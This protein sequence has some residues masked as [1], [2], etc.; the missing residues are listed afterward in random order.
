MTNFLSQIL[1][2]AQAWAYTNHSF[3]YGIHPQKVSGFCVN[4]R[5][6]LDRP[7]S[8]V[9]QLFGAE[10]PGP[11]GIPQPVDPEDAYVLVFE[12]SLAVRMHT[13]DAVSEGHGGHIPEGRFTAPFSGSGMLYSDSTVAPQ[14][15]IDGSCPLPPGSQIRRLMPDGQQP[16]IAVLQPT[17]EG[18]LR[19]Q[20]PETEFPALFPTPQ[21]ESEHELF[22]EVSGMFFPAFD[23]PMGMVGVLSPDSRA[24]WTSFPAYDF[25][26]VATQG[27]VAGY[28]HEHIDRAL[29]FRTLA[30]YEGC[31]CVVESVNI[32]QQ[33]AQVVYLGAPDP[34]LV[35]GGFVGDQCHGYRATLP[36]SVFGN[37]IAY[38]VDAF[39]PGVRPRQALPEPELLADESRQL[40][41]SFYLVEN[42]TPIP[43]WNAPT[44]DG[45]KDWV[46]LLP[47]ARS[48]ALMTP[49]AQQWWPM[50][51]GRAV[52]RARDAFPE[53][54][55]GIISSVLH[56]DDGR[57]FL[58]GV[59]QNQYVAFRIEDQRLS[60]EPFLLPP[61]AVVQRVD[62]MSAQ[63]KGQ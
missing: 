19:W 52:V 8:E 5:D 26:T 54:F 55:L 3:G 13:K 41:S 62:T 17:P 21:D 2:P 11:N 12:S 33:T 42:R 16:A 43:V 46:I 14:Y 27:V 31:R 25:L 1:A 50:E 59:R 57:Y 4:Y 61:D 38:D 36:L 34:V 32:D 47:D 49:Q 35:A 48:R 37:T 58:D 53:G 30:T 15:L 7:S 29:F 60:E 56:T 40:H 39:E 23:L 24:A 51:D 18:V 28:L 6:I 45:S 63:N 9:V 44:P 22:I 10:Q 20:A